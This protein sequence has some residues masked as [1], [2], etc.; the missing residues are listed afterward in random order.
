LKTLVIQTDRLPITHQ[1]DSLVYH[2]YGINQSDGVNS[3]PD[4]IELHSDRIRSKYVKFV[5]ELAEKDFNGITLA[6]HF[7]FEGYSLWW[8]STIV[9]KN[10]V[11]SPEISDCIK[12]IALQEI[13][14]TNKP[15]I[16]SLD[17]TDK[18]LKKAIANLCYDYN[19]QFEDASKGS[20]LKNSTRKLLVPAFVRGI[21]YLFNVVWKFWPLRKLNRYSWHIGAD[22]VFIFSQFIN[23]ELNKIPPYINSKY[24]EIF[25][26]FL[27][28][29]GVKMNFMNIFHF[30]HLTPDTKSAMSVLE[31]INDSTAQ[32]NQLHQFLYKSLSFRLIIRVLLNFISLT[33]K[34]K[35]REEENLLRS[36]D[37]KINFWPLLE[38][39]WNDSL[40]GSVL[41][42][43]LFFIALI[44]KC[45]KDLPQQKLGIYLQ[46]N[47]GW[48]RAFIQAWKTYQKSNLIGVP[49]TTIRYWDL[50]YID[51]EQIFAQSNGL[52]LP[53]PD[54]IVVNG[55]AASKVLLGSGFNP[56]EILEGEALRYLKDE[57]A[58]DEEQAI[59]N[60]KILKSS[61][62]RIILCGDIDSNST[63]AMLECVE[64]AL[65]SIKASG[66]H[67]DLNVV[68]KSHPVTKVDLKKFEIPFLNETKEDLNQILPLFDIMIATDSTSAGVEA[69]LAGLKVIVFI[70]SQRVN[71]SPLKGVDG[72]LF[73]SNE[74]SL[75]KILLSEDLLHN[76]VKPE[77]FFWTDKK[78]P[79]W[80]KIFKDAG[81]SNFN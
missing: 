24:W 45:I 38:N 68:Y 26:E 40:K 35:F 5:Y 62:K 10:L 50:R 65:S 29:K 71:F 32:H 55:P 73:V 49:H 6:E 3:I 58:I 59:W 8:M 74:Q 34:T 7:D 36:E 20:I 30:N 16:L 4:Y 53:R 43:N 63:I 69:Y 18:S 17:S 67:L 79:K 14:S 11:K 78:L 9:E 22:Q 2:W 70:Y 27:K 47:N 56:E 64:S 41:A 12:L 31:R 23:F 80:S 25:P 72:V 15:A 60:K 77:P 46:E 61:K 57:P 28:E 37:L 51:E 76:N 39:D 52:K 21:I 54:F 44:D 48:E 1:P 75:S 42:E 81:Y 66:R 19:I 33:F 13:I